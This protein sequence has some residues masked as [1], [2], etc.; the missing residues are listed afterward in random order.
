MTDEETASAVIVGQLER[1]RSTS[2]RL[3]T[4]PVSRSKRRETFTD[5]P[6][7]SRYANSNNAPSNIWYTYFKGTVSHT[8]LRS[9]AKLNCLQAL[10]IP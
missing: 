9:H 4:T 1:P 5:S 6:T 7:I 3:R 10:V 2:G 8:L